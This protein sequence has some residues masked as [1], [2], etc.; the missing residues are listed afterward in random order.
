MKEDLL[1]LLLALL[2]SKFEQP[3]Q[4]FYEFIADPGFLEGVLAGGAER[5]ADEARD[6]VEQ[7]RAAVGIA[8]LG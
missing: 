2:L 1:A 7:F 5:V 3:R 6:R 4:R 8:R